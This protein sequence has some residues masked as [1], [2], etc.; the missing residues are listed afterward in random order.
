[1]LRRTDIGTI[2]EAEEIEDC[3]SWDGVQVEF[4]S[5]STLS[6]CVELNKR[7]TIAKK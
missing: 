2:D 7:V 4:P 3:Y 5:Q 6:S 1:M